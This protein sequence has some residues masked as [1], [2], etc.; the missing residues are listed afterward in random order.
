[1]GNP[2]FNVKMEGQL[3]CDSWMPGEN[4]TLIRTLSLTGGSSVLEI[5]LGDNPEVTPAKSVSLA[6]GKPVTVTYK[7]R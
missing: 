3:L 5:P 2:T 1:M 4:G 7:L 6:P